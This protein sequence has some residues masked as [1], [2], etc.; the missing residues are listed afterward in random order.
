MS[1]RAQDEEDVSL[2]TSAA[3][4]VTARDVKVTFSPRR[5]LVALRGQS[6]VDGVLTE[7][8]HPEECTWQFGAFLEAWDCSL[9]HS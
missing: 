8:V 5:L 6:I 7:A 4:G 3:E 2:H 1:V 9:N